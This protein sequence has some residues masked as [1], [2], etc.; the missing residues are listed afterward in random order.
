MSEHPQTLQTFFTAAGNALFNPPFR[1]KIGI[2]STASL[3]FIAYFQFFYGPIWATSLVLMFVAY[4]GTVVFLGL[5]RLEKRAEDPEDQ[6]LS[7]RILRRDDLRDSIG[8]WIRA[9]FSFFM[10]YFAF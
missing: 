5:Q 1:V 7:A 6:S 4:A 8:F 2:V 9:A 3:L 10:L